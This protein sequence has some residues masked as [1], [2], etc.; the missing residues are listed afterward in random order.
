VGF[1]RLIASLNKV[2]TI[3]I[4]I[5]FLLLFLWVWDLIFHTECRKQ[6]RIFE[7]MVLRKIFVPKMSTGGWRMFHNEELLQEGG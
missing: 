5:S 2:K 6:M 7:N 4:I 3:N 1:H